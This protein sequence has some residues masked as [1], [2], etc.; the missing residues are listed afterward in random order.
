MHESEVLGGKLFSLG[1]GTR[2]SR[3]GLASDPA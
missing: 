1:G 2:E 3:L